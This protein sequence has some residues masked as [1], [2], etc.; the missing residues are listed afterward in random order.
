MSNPYVADPWIFCPVRR[1]QARLRLFC[2]PFAGGGA[3]FYRTWASELPPTIELSAVQLPGREARIREAAFTG[4]PALIAE[5]AGRLQPSMDR[6]FA[7]FGHSMGALISFEL[8]REL[9]RQRRRGPAQLFVS[10]RRAPQCPPAEIRYNLPD[11]EF[12]AAMS[13]FNGTPKEIL[14]EPE[15]LELFMP[16]LRADFSIIDTYVYTSEP[17]LD[18]PISAFGGTEDTEAPQAMIEQWREQT[19]RLFTLTMFPG[20]HFYLKNVYKDVLAQVT[21]ALQPLLGAGSPL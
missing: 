3:S 12:V 14:A 13:S 17:P 8:A 5:L 10:G 11:Q 21:G 15:L 4:L 20:D 1:P 9:R 18:C 16:I 7:F 6:P 2:F 19:T